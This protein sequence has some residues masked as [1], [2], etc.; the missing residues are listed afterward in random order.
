MKSFWKWIWEP[1]NKSKLEL[2][3]VDELRIFLISLVIAFILVGLICLIA[4]ILVKI[5]A[6]K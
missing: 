6:V 2:T 1:F 3:T 4:F 5:G